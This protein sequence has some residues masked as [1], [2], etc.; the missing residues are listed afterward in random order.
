MDPDAGTNVKHLPLSIWPDW[1]PKILAYLTT[2]G[3]FA[4]LAGLFFREIPSLNMQPLLILLG[5]V[6]T[7]WLII[8]G[9][10]FTQSAANVS[11]DAV[12]ANTE[13]QVSTG[14]IVKSIT[15]SISTPDPPEEKP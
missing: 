15:T 1:T 3:V 5:S 13:A 6:T 10:Y 11:R 14:Q 9:Y 7:A 4:C 2:F 8:M 12:K